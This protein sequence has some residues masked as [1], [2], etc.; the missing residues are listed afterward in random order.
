M[1]GRICRNLHVNLS[2]VGALDDAPID[3]PGQIVM[4]ALQV[5]DQL[6]PLGADHREQLRGRTEC[7]GSEGIPVRMAFFARSMDSTRTASASL[8]TWI[9]AVFMTAIASKKPLKPLP[10]K[11]SQTNKSTSVLPCGWRSLTELNRGNIEV[12]RGDTSRM[13]Q[14]RDGL[15]SRLISPETPSRICEI[16]ATQPGRRARSCS[17]AADTIA[18]E[19]ARSNDLVGLNQME[20]LRPTAADFTSGPGPP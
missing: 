4:H 20:R 19:H 9:R 6:P 7:E 10:G 15:L 5:L 1:P 3:Q 11:Q 16:D 17:A 2:V 18:D 14:L 8:R 13:V 12:T